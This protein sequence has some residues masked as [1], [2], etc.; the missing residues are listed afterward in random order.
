M[1]A[2]WYSLQCQRFASCVRTKSQPVRDTDAD[3]AVHR[4]VFLHYE[5]QALTLCIKVEIFWWLQMSRYACWSSI[6]KSNFRLSAE[7][8]LTARTRLAYHTLTYIPC[9]VMQMNIGL[10]PWHIWV[11]IAVCLF[12]GEVFLPTFFLA[13]LGLGALVGAAAH[14]I[15]GDLGWG[16]GSFAIGSSIS[17]I[18]IR[19]YF[20][21]LL[22]PEEPSSFG[23]SG[24][25]GDLIVVTDASDV[26]G[27]LKAKYRDSLWSLKSE[28][29]LFEGDRVVITSVDGSTLIVEKAEEE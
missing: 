5:I 16:I 6:W 24:M 15:S 12:I 17:L 28:Q 19:P 11:I 8:Y 23:A 14:Q 27:T 20:T 21:K 1:V 4:L 7:Y 9:K 2:G 18:L 22:A 13:S 26:G 29:D 25:I 10:E 3:D